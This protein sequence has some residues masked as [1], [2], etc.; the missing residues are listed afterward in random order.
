MPVSVL[1]VMRRLLAIASILLFG[2][3]RLSGG[4]LA[5]KQADIDPNAL[6]DAIFGFMG[7]QIS[8]TTDLT[9][10]SEADSQEQRNQLWA[11]AYKHLED[12]R[13]KGTQ[14]EDVVPIAGDTSGPDDSV[15]DGGE[16]G[17]RLVSLLTPAP[18]QPETLQRPFVMFTGYRDG[19][20]QMRVFSPHGLSRTERQR[21]TRVHFVLEPLDTGGKQRL[22]NWLTQVAPRGSGV[23]VTSLA[24]RGYC[25]EAGKAAPAPDDVF[26]A[27]SRAAREQFKPADAV[28]VAG[29]VAAARGYLHPQGDAAAYG[30][31]VTQYAIW[32]RLEH[33][34]AARF[35]D[36][37]AKR[38]KEAAVRQK[39]EW[40]SRTE[41]TARLS[42]RPRWD[43]VQRVLASADAVQ[44][45][46]R[47]SSTP[48]GVR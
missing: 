30:H 37:F 40:T 7:A 42:A 44:R 43:D 26:I 12:E 25:V 18:P 15:M 9:D 48:E 4:P 17:F 38:T 6:A 8:D 19:V 27:A 24:V 11:A 10:D 34:D 47:T 1:P 45:R 29:D 16:P 35:T 31:F 41:M 36:E 33:W 2:L 14:Y 21:L 23:H 39:L 32:T 28:R 3:V 22:Q 20:I 5:Q 46:I 13:K